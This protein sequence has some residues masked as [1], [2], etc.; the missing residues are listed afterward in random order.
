MSP[1]AYSL[2]SLSLWVA[3]YI[4]VARFNKWK[5]RRPSQ[6][7]ISEKQHIFFLLWAS[8]KITRSMLILK[9]LLLLLWN[10][11][12]T[13][14]PTLVTLH[15]SIWIFNLWC[16]GTV[17]EQVNTQ[18][19]QYWRINQTYFSNR[20]TDAG[21]NSLTC[22]QLPWHINSGDPKSLAL[23]VLPKALVY[24]MVPEENEFYDKISLDT[25]A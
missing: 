13:R 21:I 9:K 23:K 11:H 5:Y 10:S 15:C 19:A 8:S 14:C 20:Q 7:W 25:A 1:G 6:I 2:L 12:L 24:D 16:E 22:L 18:V 17:S 4:R 3:S